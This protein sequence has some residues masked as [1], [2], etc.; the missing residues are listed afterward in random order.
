MV[1]QQHKFAYKDFDFTITER[2]DLCFAYSVCGEN[3][4]KV[5]IPGVLLDPDLSKEE[6]VQAVKD[7]VDGV[8]T[9]EVEVY[10]HHRVYAGV[11]ETA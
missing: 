5:W 1:T 7:M 10:G 8:F 6:M 4:D 11:K 9:G 3:G 2:P